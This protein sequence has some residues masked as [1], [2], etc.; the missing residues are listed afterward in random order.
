MTAVGF[1]TVSGFTGGTAGTASGQGATDRVRWEFETGQL[2]TSSPTVVD[3]T[4]FAGSHDR[5]LYAVDADTGDE[6]WSFRADDDAEFWTAPAVVDETVYV[7]SLSGGVYALQAESGERVWSE[8]VAGAS[9]PT[10]GTE[11]VYVGGHDGVTAF[12]RE[13]GEEAWHTETDATAGPPVVVDDVVFAS[14]WSLYALDAAT[15]DEFWRLEP[16]ESAFSVPTLQDEIL[17]AMVGDRLSAIDGRTGDPQWFVNLGWLGYRMLTV[18]SDTAYLGVEDGIVHAVDTEEASLRWSELYPSDTEAPPTVADNAVF[19]GSVDG[20]VR[21]LSA[22]Q[23]SKSWQI[24]LDGPLRSAPTV[25]EGTVYVASGGTLY[26][27]DADIDGSS[28]CSRVA[29][30][31]LGHHDSWTGEAHE[32]VNVEA[33]GHQQL[34]ESTPTSTPTPTAESTP[35]PTPTTENT[36]DPTPTPDTDDS[37]PGFGIAGGLLAALAG[38][39]FLRERSRGN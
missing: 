35:D 25:V 32:T 24:E 16:Q 9:S 20:V 3:G 26:A 6:E 28:T 14:G 38:G 22:S 11:Q 12:D 27:L 23:G 8:S 10:A 1:G 37:G 39:Y 29:W 30:G 36:L 15:G 7:S 4:V 17:Y 2:V 18:E 19:I 21:S 33:T 34:R 13:T 31:T 5:N